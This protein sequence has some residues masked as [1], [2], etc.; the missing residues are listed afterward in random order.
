M[1]SRYGTAL[2]LDRRKLGTFALIFPLHSVI[3]QDK[4]LV[5]KKQ[6]KCSLLFLWEL[7]IPLITLHKKVEE[8]L[9][10]AKNARKEMCVSPFKGWNFEKCGFEWLSSSS[11]NKYPAYVSTCKAALVNI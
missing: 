4:R 8:Q 7:D 10:L 9:F 3:D 5:W 2:N 6:P 1:G 11:N